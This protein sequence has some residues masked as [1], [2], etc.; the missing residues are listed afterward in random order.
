MTLWANVTD[1]MG[2]GISG[3]TVSFITVVGGLEKKL[4]ISIKSFNGIVKFE[5]Y[6]DLDA[7][8]MLFVEIIL[9]LMIIIFSTAC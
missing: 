4:T 1:D 2:N 9:V 5:Y 8:F 6:V 7:V 3:K